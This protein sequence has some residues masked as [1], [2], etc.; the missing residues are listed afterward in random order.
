[1]QE[2][3]EPQP[4]YEDWPG[5]WVGEDAWPSPR[6]APRTFELDVGNLAEEVTDSRALSFRSPQTTGLRG[7]EWC[8]FGV[9]GEMPPDQRPD[10]GGSLVFDSDPLDER[11]E[12]LGAPVL[13]VEVASDRPVALLG[14]RLRPVQWL[15][16]AGILVGMVA[17][18]IP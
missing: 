15:G 7:G 4:Q 18:A 6:I 12:V 1:M 13:E 8:G 14:E 17:I 16:L 11:I 3:V 10:D 2:W 9:D 5:R